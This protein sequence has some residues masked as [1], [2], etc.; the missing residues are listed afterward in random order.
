VVNTVQEALGCFS[1]G[2]IHT[3]ADE[4]LPPI[5]CCGGV[6]TGGDERRWWGWSRSAGAWSGV[7]EGGGS[8]PCRHG[9]AL[10][11]AA[12]TSD[13]DAMPAEARG[14]RSRGPRRH[15]TESRDEVV[16]AGLV[17]AWKMMKR[18][19]MTGTDSRRASS[20]VGIPARMVALLG[21][22]LGAVEAAPGGTGA[23]AWHGAGGAGAAAWHQLLGPAASW[24]GVGR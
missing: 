14:C 15:G 7:E 9:T 22:R 11:S 6:P 23:A 1:V 17:P 8:M 3:R 18:A 12:I 4:A 2:Q 5:C 24:I 13:E 10:W 19:S 21:L 20:V 16:G